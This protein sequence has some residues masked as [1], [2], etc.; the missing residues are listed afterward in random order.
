M[1]QVRKEDQVRKEET[2]S[3][4]EVWTQQIEQEEKK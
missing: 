3:P 2:H 4:M 1:Q